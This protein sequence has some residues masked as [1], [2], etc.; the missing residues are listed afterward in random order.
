M[1]RITEQCSNFK[2]YLNNE[3]GIINFGNFLCASTFSLKSLFKLLGE[4]D[5]NV[6]PVYFRIY[7]GC[8][9]DG[10]GHKMFL[11]LLD[12]GM[13]VIARTELID[14]PVENE[15][16]CPPGGSCLTDSFIKDL[17]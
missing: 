17:F 9:E 2:D 1:E 4:A 12:A 11:A 3:F 7:Y 8:D 6:Q 10:S 15:H 5:N 13:N 16:R 14:P